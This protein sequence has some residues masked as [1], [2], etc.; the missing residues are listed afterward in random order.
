[1]SQVGF[2]MGWNTGAGV[3]V[4][5]AERLR[6]NMEMLY[7]E[8]ALY[9]QFVE[10]PEIPLDKITLR[11]IEAPIFLSYPFNI[12]GT[13]K[14]KKFKQSIGGGITYAQLFNYKMVAVDGSDLTN[15]VQLDQKNAILININA[16][17]TLN[18]SF[19]MDA[20]VSIALFGDLTYALRLIYTL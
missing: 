2:R 20:R 6:M 15:D 14:K 9:V 8:N 5:L 7:S 1:M 12:D 16:T 4:K 19:A 11:F 17:S 18:D 13:E 10:T 3:S